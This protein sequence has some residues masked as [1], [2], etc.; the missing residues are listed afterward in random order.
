MG[1]CSLVAQTFTNESLLVR[2]Q[3]PR[4]RGTEDPMLETALLSAFRA[5]DRTALGL[6]YSRYRKDVQGLVRSALLISRR[7]SQA[8]VDDV[9]QEVFLRAFSN[10]ARAQYDGRRDYRPFL[11][12][13]ARNVLF[14]WCRRRKREVPS[15]DTLEIASE[16]WG[17]DRLDVDPAP[18]V[19]AL[20]D[21]VLEYARALPAELNGVYHQR[22]VLATTQE[23]AASSLEL[24][25]QTVRTLERRILEGLRRHL[26]QAGFRLPTSRIS[27]QRLARREPH[28]VNPSSASLSSGTRRA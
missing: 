20:L 23:H 28:D 11:L 4:G 24:S 16:K 6:V 1:Q 7:A 22:F 12:A 8:D 9:V 26:I 19:A 10:D 25:R 2:Y 15:S 13:M 5:G 17:V 27:V 3:L 21:S 14:D 18:G